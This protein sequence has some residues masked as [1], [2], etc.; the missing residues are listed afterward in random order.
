VVAISD[1][2]FGVYKDNSAL[3]VFGSDVVFAIATASVAVI[4]ALACFV[5]FRGRHA[6]PL[7]VAMGALI[8]LLAAGVVVALGPL[9]D[10]V[11]AKPSSQFPPTH[12]AAGMSVLEPARLH[13]Y[14]VL[15]AAP[16]AWLA[17]RILAAM[18]KPSP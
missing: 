4:S 3:N 8:Q 2:G 9:V 16:V 12:L 13:A 10:G 6:S 15:A 5:K 11:A 1:Q 17:T 14:G 7:T 18:R